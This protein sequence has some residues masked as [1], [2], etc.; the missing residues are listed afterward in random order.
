MCEKMLGEAMTLHNLKL[1]AVLE[2]LDVLERDSQ[3][4]RS[5]QLLLAQRVLHLNH[6]SM[7]HFDLLEL[8]HA[9]CDPS[10]PGKSTGTGTI[11]QVYAAAQQSLTSLEALQAGLDM[12]ETH[13]AAYIHHKRGLIFAL[14]SQLHQRHQHWDHAIENDMI[15]IS[16]L[17]AAL[18]VITAEQG[19]FP[20]FVLSYIHAT[21]RLA[22]SYRQH[23]R[24]SE[25]AEWVNIALTNAQLLYARTSSEER[26]RGAE[27][28]SVHA[29]CR[30]IAADLQDTAKVAYHSREIQKLTNMSRT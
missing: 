4:Q 7:L 1:Q 26:L 19:E 5:S 20:G 21:S 8:T 18:Q 9:R 12:A 13:N 6:L 23:L 22:E 11:E 24:L 10:A 15:C 27:L 17:S 25:A 14:L 30:A 29:L 16:E 28:H 3:R 2:E